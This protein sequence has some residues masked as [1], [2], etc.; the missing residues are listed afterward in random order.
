MS[1]KCEQ[2]VLSVCILQ[3]KIF[4]CIFAQLAASRSRPLS[5]CCVQFQANMFNCELAV[6]IYH[7][8]TPQLHLHFQQH[9]HHHQ[10]HQHKDDVESFVMKCLITLLQRI[11]IN[12]RARL[13]LNVLVHSL[14]SD[15]GLQA[16]GV[17][18]KQISPLN[19]LI[20][21]YISIF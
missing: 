10:H 2:L 6:I 7:G 20:N 11:N 8:A 5:E 17:A 4:C 16:E 9:K 15:K 12:L 18:V 21:K 19:R 13:L 14:H 1:Q 3:N